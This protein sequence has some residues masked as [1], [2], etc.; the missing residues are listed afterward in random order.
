[1]RGM[2]LASAI[3]LAFMIGAAAAQDGDLRITHVWSRATAPGQATGVVYMT[4][5]SRKGDT[6][7]SASVPVADKAA[8]HRSTM[9][10]GVM[11]MR[12]VDALPVQPGQATVLKPGGLHLM[13]IGLKQPLK[14]G[15]TFPLTLMFRDAGTRVV[16]VKVEKAGATGDDMKGHAH[17]MAKP[18]S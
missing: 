3:G 12:P 2:I 17:E 7:I 1:M 14:E 9:E 15:A 6:L 18:G 11:K 8:L 16:D 13:L 10:N 5:E 4:I